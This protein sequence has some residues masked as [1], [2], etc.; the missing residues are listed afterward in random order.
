MA[1]Q[2]VAYESLPFAAPGA[3]C[4]AA[5]AA[6]SSPPSRDGVDRSLDLLAHHFWL[7]RRR[8]AQAACTWAAPPTR[9]GRPTRT[10]RRST[11]SS[12]SCRSSTARRVI[13]AQLK[14]AKVL[15][16][17]RRARPRAEAVAGEARSAAEALGDPLEV[18]WADASL[19][20]T[21]K[22]QSHFEAATARLEAA[23]ATFQAAK[24]NAGV[25]DMLHLAG[26]VAQL[27]GDYPAAKSRYEDS[28]SVR[29]EIGDVAGVATT[30]GNLAILAEFDG[31]Y[32]AALAINDRALA[33]RRQIGD[34]RG[35]GIGEMNAGYYRILNGHLESARRHLQEALR[36]S[37]ELGDRAMV[38]H[39]TFTLGNAERDLGD[40]ASAAARYGDALQ[41][42][43]ELDDRFSLTFIV[44][45][46]GVL[47]AR[48]GEEEQ[49]FELL[50][51]AEAIRAQIGS[52]R[53]PTLE[54]ELEGHLARRGRRSATPS[55]TPRWRTGG[56][57]RSR[58]RSTRR[59]ER[60]RAWRRQ[61]DRRADRKRTW[62]ANAP[63]GGP[64]VSTTAAI[65]VKTYPNA[66]IGPI[67]AALA[68]ASD[69]VPVAWIPGG[70][71]D[72]QPWRMSPCPS[73][74]PP[75]ASPRSSRHSARCPTPDH[76]H[77]GRP[78]RS[79]DWY[80]DRDWSGRR[81]RPPRRTTGGLAQIDYNLDLGNAS[82]A[83]GTWT[84][85]STAAADEAIPVQYAWSGLHAWFQAVARLRPFVIPAGGT[86]P[87]YGAYLYDKG[88][89]NCCDGEPSNGFTTSGETR[90]PS[91]SATPSASS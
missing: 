18:A 27:Q 75:A 10:P 43:R 83:S 31:D 37:R 52:P 4:T 90:S 29:D 25:G 21:A 71:R 84:F 1:T 11:T 65:G 53:P 82:G 86:D 46:V 45:D 47:L 56:P 19:A 57:G 13:E 17:R 58:T 49:G 23:L 9:R 66:V 6:T 76:D 16:A 32:P 38:A 28:R 15:P 33:L 40:L 42:Q 79:T 55:R 60:L 80:L 26:V 22:R 24:E 30:D 87:T 54:V 44:E 70:C 35:I 69:D 39:S 77:A 48:A 81:Y 3:C 67:L 85:S 78:G 14:L 7:E 50:G 12:A 8:R 2:E 64:V 51:G 72:P 91:P 73:H 62:R 89:T 88:P 5:S 63:L 59:S 36:L 20:E 68:R 41:L 74:G 34:R 61:R